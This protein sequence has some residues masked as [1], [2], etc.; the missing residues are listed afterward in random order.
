MAASASFDRARQDAALALEAGA[1]HIFGPA[2]ALAERIGNGVFG[3]EE[4]TT[5]FD[6]N[7]AFLFQLGQRTADGEAAD[8][9]MAG[10]IELGHKLHAGDELA[11]ADIFLSDD[12]TLR[13]SRPRSWL[14]PPLMSPVSAIEAMF[15]I[16][17]ASL[18]ARPGSS[19]DLRLT[20]IILAIVIRVKQTICKGPYCEI[21]VRTFVILGLRF[22]RV[23]LPPKNGRGGRMVTTVNGFAQG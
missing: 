22:C 13:H 23:S 10:H 14:S 12:A 20:E 9:E 11:A 8:V 17:C 1:A 21:K 18:A 16:L 5:M 15:P 2:R 7:Q 19:G 3:D 6:A 4:T